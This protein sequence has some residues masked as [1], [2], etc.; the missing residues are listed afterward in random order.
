VKEIVSESVILKSKLESVTYRD[1]YKKFS[2]VGIASGDIVMIHSRIF[3]LGKIPIDV[4]KNE[5]TDALINTI[6]NLVGPTGTLIFPTFTL[7]TCKNTNFDL[8]NSASEMG[9]LSERARLRGDG[10]RTSHP[11]YSTVIF[12]NQPTEL[13]NADISSCFGRDS[14]FGVLHS[15]NKT[16]KYKNRVKFLTIG[17]DYP[18]E[19][20]TYIHF[21]EECMGVPYRYHKIFPCKVKLEDRS[22]DIDVQ[23]FVRNLA[24]DVIFDKRSSWDLLQH[25]DGVKTTKLGD[26]LISIVPEDVLFNSIKFALTEKNDFLCVGGYH[27]EK[28]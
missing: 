10:I 26:S 17:L 5:F 22:F 24:A 23:F 6:G 8:I 19:A 14:F 18:T 25:Q 27:A 16:E 7:S 21:I 15:M 1:L 4:N 9:A 11:I 3:T 2:F 28:S 12:G 13:L 20:L